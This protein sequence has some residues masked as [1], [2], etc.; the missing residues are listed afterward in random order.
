MNDY[1]KELDTAIYQANYKLTQ[2]DAGGGNLVLRVYS[3]L[4]VRLMITSINIQ[5]SVSGGLRLE[6]YVYDSNDDFISN[7]G[8]DTSFGA[9]SILNFPSTGQP[10]TNDNNMTSAQNVVLANG[11]YLRIRLSSAPVN[12]QLQV[13]IRGFIRGRVPSIDTSASGGTVSLSTIYSRII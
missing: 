10:A 1:F 2:T 12:T 9:G 5:S 8:L 3:T 4:G 13:R 11:D 7:L 6:N